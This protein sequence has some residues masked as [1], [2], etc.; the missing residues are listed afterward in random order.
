MRSTSLIRSS[1]WRDVSAIPLCSLLFLS[2]Q[3]LY[4]QAF[5]AILSTIEIKALP[6][7]LLTVHANSSVQDLISLCKPQSCRICFHISF[8]CFFVF[9]RPKTNYFFNVMHVFIISKKKTTYLTITLIN[10]QQSQPTR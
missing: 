7:T 9:L 3:I 5:H 6:L 2:H 4:M 10:A 1:N 8:F